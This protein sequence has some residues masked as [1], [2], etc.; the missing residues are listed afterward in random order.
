MRGT[1]RTIFIFSMEPW[2]DMWY[3]KHHYATR[4]AREHTVY[5]VSLPDRWR[6]KDLFSFGLKVT[7]SKEGVNVVEYRNNL[8]LRFLP[9]WLRDRID[10][11]NVTKLRRLYP[12]DPVVL[13][14]FYPA[15]LL[16]ID[17]LRRKGDRLIYHV[18]DPFQVLPSDTTLARKADLVVSINSWYL[19]YY[20]NINRSCILVPHGV[21]EQD[22]RQ[23]PAAI[24]EHRGK[25]GRYIVLAAS[26]THPTNY[27]ILRQVAERFPATSLVLIGELLPVPDSVSRI[28]E[29]LLGMDNVVHLGALPPD[30]MRDVVGGAAVGLVTYEFQRTLREPQSGVRTPLKVLTYV[31]QGCPVVTTINGFIAELDGKAVYKAED[32][33]HFLDLIATALEGG[34]EFDRSAVRSYLDRVEYDR[35]IEK[36]FAA[37]DAGHVPVLEG[38]T[39]DDRSRLPWSCP[40]MVVSNESWDG[41]RY[42]KHR[43]ALELCKYRKVF[44][45]DPPQA[46]R[47]ANLFKWRVRQRTIPEGITILSYHNPTPLFNGLLGPLN[48]W[49]IGR[50]LHGFMKRN[51]WGAPLFWSFDPNRLTDPAPLDPYLSIY[52]CV[53]DHGLA[54]PGELRLATRVD[55]V[56]CIARGLM[57]RFAA[58]NTSVLHVPHGIADI[59]INPHIAR[60]AAEQLV[61]GYGLYI[62]SVNDRHDF[63]LWR[64]L[65]V[66][67]S[68]IQWVVVGIATP[69]DP[70][71]LELLGGEVYPNVKYMGPVAYESIGALVK[72]AGF[73]FLYLHPDHP[74][75][76]IS[77]QKV[78]QF[79]AQ[80]KPF[81]SSWLSEYEAHPDVVYISEGHEAAVGQFA[82]WR[83]RGDDH[84]AADR[85]KAYAEGLRF[86]VLLERLPF[87]VHQPWN[88]PDA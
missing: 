14:A 41:P 52:H 78:V 15:N 53:D 9:K 68:D 16:T 2:G 46:W 74:A 59:D 36:V 40:V 49:I 65:I 18:V 77:S 87:N 54:F 58:L 63:E 85:R 6:L 26:L 61:P 81:F 20:R 66:A 86:P 11:L 88:D 69:T 33:R 71:G 84:L 1:S 55:H 22:T 32:E 70:V 60:T 72:N 44:F 12:K 3:S 75:N 19:S 76:R 39:L 62:G 29:Q 28:R 10:R 13:W 83:M 67:N 25:W 37:L 27:K 79:L 48:D 42:S 8:P 45:V 23:N 34:L 17:A 57:P 80:G 82:R 43:Y 21:R 51:G 47:P 38:P 7:R 35:L 73:G 30:A 56:F 24:A 4:L 5:F 50:R 31:A 64:K